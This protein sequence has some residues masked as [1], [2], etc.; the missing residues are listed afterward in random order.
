MKQKKTVQQEKKRRTNANG[1]ISIQGSSNSST[2]VVV[3]SLNGKAL[4]S[5]GTIILGKG[6]GHKESNDYFCNKITKILCAI[7]IGGIVLGPR[8]A[9]ERES[10]SNLNDI[11]FCIKADM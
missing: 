11:P 10:E 4:Y 8:E 5:Q 6:L 2:R 9:S 3:Y 1:A 7:A